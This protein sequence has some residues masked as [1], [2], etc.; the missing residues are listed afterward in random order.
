MYPQQ[1][2]TDSRFPRTRQRDS[3]IVAAPTSE[4]LLSLACRLSVA[5]RRGRG[6]SHDHLAIPLDYGVLWYH[7]KTLLPALLAATVAWLPRMSR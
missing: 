7:S 3:S 1:Q 6:Y 2:V 5:N 4:C